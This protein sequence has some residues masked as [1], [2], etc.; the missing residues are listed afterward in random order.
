MPVAEQ[1]VFYDRYALIPRV[2]IFATRAESV[3]LIKGA[4]TKRLW[5]NLYNGVGGHIEQGEDV[6]TAARREFKEE[7]GLALLDPWL[8][9]LVT[10]DTGKV[11][12]IGMYVFRAQAGPGE[13][14]PSAEGGL[15]WIPFEQ[16]QQLPLV[17]DLPILLPTVLAMQPGELPRY[18]QYSYN[19]DDQLQIEFST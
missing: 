9:A 7:T 4:P 15:A 10:I 13:L 11:P 12:G 2:L 18:A 16:L 5:A 1:G 19:T 8:C 14:Q 17:E 3:L 6:L